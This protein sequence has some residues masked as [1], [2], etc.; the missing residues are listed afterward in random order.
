MN[1]RIASFALLR[2]RLIPTLYI[3]VSVLVAVYVTLMVTTILFAAL[4]TKLAQ[5]VQDT[6]M[7]ISRLETSYYDAIA[8]LNAT[9]PQTLGYIKPTKVQYVSA[10][11]LPNLTFARN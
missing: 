6:R 3:L 4:Q 8:Q 11:A 2:P 10:S 7:E 1:A 9:N 5:N